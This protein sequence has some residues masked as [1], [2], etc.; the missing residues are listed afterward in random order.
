[1]DI[2]GKL[3]GKKEAIPEAGRGETANPANEPAKAVTGRTRIPL[4]LPRLKL[5]APKIPGYVLQWFADRPGRLR[6][7]Q[8]AGY[9]HVSPDEISLNNHAVA[10]DPASSGNTDLGN[11]VSTYGGVGE[12]GQAERLYLMKIPEQYWIEDEK[13]K[14]DRNESVAAAIRGG[15]TPMMNPD[16]RNPSAPGDQ[17][18]VYGGMGARPGGNPAASRNSR[19]NLFTRKRG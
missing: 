14:A 19:A 1:M 7:A 18:L 4:S 16:A 12:G 10:D 8:E 13:V 9:E 3:T 17:S 15:A 2:L 6:Q 11:Q 5:D